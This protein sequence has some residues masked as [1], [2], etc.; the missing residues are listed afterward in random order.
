MILSENRF[1]LF[2]IMNFQWCMIFSENRFPLFRIMNFQWCM[3]FSE[4]RFPLFRIMHYCAPESGW[5]VVAMRVVI[6]SSRQP[7]CAATFSASR[8]NCAGSDAR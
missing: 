4:N 2:R 3:I 6:S 1:P 5:P 7:V 8:R